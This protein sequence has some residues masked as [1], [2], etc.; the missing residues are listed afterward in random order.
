LRGLG[1]LRDLGGDK[2]L[3]SNCQVICS[4]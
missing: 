4:S 1:C 2:R 3:Y